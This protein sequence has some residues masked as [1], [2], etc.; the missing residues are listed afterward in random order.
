MF[1]RIFRFYQASKQPPQQ[2]QPDVASDFDAWVGRV[3][4]DA[5]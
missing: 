4:F 5:A 2:Q 1:R 3:I